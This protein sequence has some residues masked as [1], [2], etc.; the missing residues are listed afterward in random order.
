MKKLNF[1]FAALFAVCLSAVFTSCSDDDDNFDSGSIVGKWQSVSGIYWEIENGELYGSKTDEVSDNSLIM[2]FSEDGVL[3][4]TDTENG[5]SE[6]VNY[7]IEGNRLV[8]IQGSEKYDGIKILKLTSDELIIEEHNKG[9]DEGEPFEV[10]Q[11]I[12]F[13][14]I[15]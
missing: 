8:L 12:K 11:K 10:Y 2:E 7:K 15:N 4:Q 5:D 1:L 6:S 3:T 14:R 9:I 13:R